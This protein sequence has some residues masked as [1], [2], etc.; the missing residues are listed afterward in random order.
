MERLFKKH[1]TVNYTKRT[2]ESS[3]IIKEELDTAKPQ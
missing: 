2:A 3:S 1:N